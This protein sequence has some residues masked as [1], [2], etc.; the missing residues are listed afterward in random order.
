MK[1][2]LLPLFVVL[3]LGSFSAYSQVGIGTNNPDPSA[4]L[5]VQATNRGV[6]IPNVKLTSTTDVV[7]INNPAESLL[8]FNAVTASDVTPGYYY[9][10]NNKWNR[11]ALSGEST[12]LNGLDGKDG[13]DGL[14]G[15]AGV[16]GAR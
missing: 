9:W 6:L 14:A 10:L 13:K 12:G 16:P 3:G 11:I 1:N 7:T 15:A 4:Q 5:H 2:K 8:V